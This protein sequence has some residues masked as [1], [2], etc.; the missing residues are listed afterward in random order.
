MD[1]K[2]ELVTPMMTPEEIQRLDAANAQV[3]TEARRV[4]LTAT[5]ARLREHLARVGESPGIV[6]AIDQANAELDALKGTP[7]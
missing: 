1:S 3:A 2:Y 4:E 6:T 7:A 5:V